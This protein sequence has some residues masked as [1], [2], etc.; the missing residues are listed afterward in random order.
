MD[1][2]DHVMGDDGRRDACDGLRMARVQRKPMKSRNQRSEEEGRERAVSR[3]R[4]RRASDG[5]RR[6]VT[7]RDKGAY[8]T[9]IQGH[10]TTPCKGKV[11][12]RE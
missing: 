11:T 2:I 3:M 6:R 10:N 5:R 1:G 7:K 4:R 9:T 12:N 8:E